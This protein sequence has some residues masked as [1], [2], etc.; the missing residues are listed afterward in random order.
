MTGQYYFEVYT[1]KN[2]KQGLKEIF[3]HNVPNRII[4]NSQEMEEAQDR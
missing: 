2:G 1:Q 3:V 4:L